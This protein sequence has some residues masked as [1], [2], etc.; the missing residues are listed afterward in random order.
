MK[1][2]AARFSAPAFLLAALSAP[3]WAQADDFFDVDLE[4]ALAVDVSRSMDTE[5]QRI[6][7]QGYIA[8]FHHPDVIEA[9]RTGPLG[10]IAVT[11]FEWAGPGDRTTI[12]P[13]TLVETA[14]DG[15]DFAGLLEQAS[16]TRQSGTSIS[17]AILY[18]GS[19][20]GE[21]FNG[22]RRVVD[23]SGDGPNNAG[24]P[25][26]DARD[27][28][29]DHGVTI[30]G[31]PIMLNRVYGYGP[32]GIPEL[33]V[34]FEDCVIGGPG[35]F[36]IPVRDTDEFADAIRRKL[37]LEIAG[38]PPRFMFAAADAAEPRVDCL[39]GEKTRRGMFNWDVPGES[40][41]GRR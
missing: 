19:L 1:R 24:R 16:I 9:I 41:P 38:L 40:T 28:L 34:Y 22:Y 39:I 30:N 12:V 25:V 5:E 15:A 13:W 2:F 31:L 32:Y 36:V 8:A 11:Y 20:F 29:L 4:L 23:I 17:G 26:E 3:A 37:V 35:A 21:T 18:A 14:A 6:Q 27:W 10:R 33:D 7:R